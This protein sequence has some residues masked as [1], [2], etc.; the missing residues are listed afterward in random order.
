MQLEH[1]KETLRKLCTEVENLT[2]E[3]FVY[4]DAI[5]ESRSINLPALKERVAQ[6]QL[7]PKR[8]KEVHQMYSEM[9]KAVDGTGTDAFF[10]DLL[11]NLPPSGKPN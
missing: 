1:F 8:R 4:Y 5:L 11:K 2:I 7:D 10:E 3:N 9:W 6:A